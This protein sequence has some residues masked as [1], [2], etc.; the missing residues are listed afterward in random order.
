MSLV[1]K[2]QSQRLFNWF[3]F[4]IATIGIQKTKDM[5]TALIS[6]IEKKEADE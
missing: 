6:Y 1:E 4:A 5:L 2:E 3:S